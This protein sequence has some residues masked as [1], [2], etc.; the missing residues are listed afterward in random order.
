MGGNRERGPIRKLCY[1]VGTLYENT[2]PCTTRKGRGQRVPREG[3]LVPPGSVHAWPTSRSRRMV[4]TTAAHLFTAWDTVG[5]ESAVRRDHRV[6]F[7][8]RLSS[9]VAAALVVI[10]KRHSEGEI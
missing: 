2:L 10:A 5:T 4:A 3:G 7:L 9:N 6:R 8:L 1:I